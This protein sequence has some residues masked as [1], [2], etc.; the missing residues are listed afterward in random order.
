MDVLDLSLGEKKSRRKTQAPQ[1][2]HT[3]SNNMKDDDSVETDPTLHQD[4]DV[5]SQKEEEESLE[6]NDQLK[7]DLN[8]SKTF[9][10]QSLTPEAQSAGDGASLIVSPYSSNSDVENAESR[11]PEQEL[12]K[13]P[14]PSGSSNASHA[15]TLGQ[16]PINFLANDNNNNNSSNNLSFAHFQHLN[17]LANSSQAFDRNLE[18]VREI[19]NMTNFRDRLS[20][21]ASSM[22]N[23]FVRPNTKKPTSSIPFSSFDVQPIDTPGIPERTKKQNRWAFNVWREWARKRNVAVSVI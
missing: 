16:P 13:S 23:S 2:R 22:A 19:P 14:S 10:N 15:I 17:A 8:T 11:R 7:I 21:L 1:R 4:D 18:N 12:G 20:G 5:D 3:I 9:L 6:Q